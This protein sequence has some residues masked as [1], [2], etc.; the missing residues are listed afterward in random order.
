MALLTELTHKY[1]LYMSEEMSWFSYLQN[2]IT[3]VYQSSANKAY[4][5]NLFF[6]FILCLS[7]II[8]KTILVKN[9]IF[10][11]V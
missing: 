5:V 3:P 7:L 1:G 11:G 4:P 6:T 10:L 9:Y 2:L 8:F